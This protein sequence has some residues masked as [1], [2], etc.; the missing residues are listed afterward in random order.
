MLFRSGGSKRMLR[1]A[2]AGDLPEAVFR[3]RKMGF[4]VPIGEWFRKGLRP[5]LHDLLMG[6]NS[7]ALQHFNM[8]VV[9]RLLSE[10][11]QGR[12]DHTQRLYALL[13]L[14]LWWQ[15]R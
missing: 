3:R 6:A 11:E 14:E 5:M 8:P 15:N 12:R 4:A 13:M 7:F 2:F 9:L 1:E 10:H